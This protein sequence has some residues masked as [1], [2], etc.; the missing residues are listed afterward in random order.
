MDTSGFLPKGRSEATLI[1]REL[2]SVDGSMWPC[3]SEP[4]TLK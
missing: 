3:V 2:L 1:S 4:S